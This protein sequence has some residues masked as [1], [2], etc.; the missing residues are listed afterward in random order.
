MK[1]EVLVTGAN[2]KPILLELSRHFAVHFLPDAPD[3]DAMLDEVCSS[4]RANGTLGTYGA[5]RAFIEKFPKLKILCCFGAGFDS[6]DC[7]AVRDHDMVFTHAA[8]TNADG[9]ADLVFAHIL[10]CARPHPHGG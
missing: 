10:A 5:S 9:V 7:D 8:G 4:V 1:I 2:C 6:V 3:Q